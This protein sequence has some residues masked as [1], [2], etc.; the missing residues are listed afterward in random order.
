M[1]LPCRWFLGKDH[2]WPPSYGTEGFQHPHYFGAFN[3]VVVFEAAQSIWVTVLS[4]AVL[5]FKHFTL[6]AV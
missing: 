6:L 2:T 4:E 3:P 1:F 5:F